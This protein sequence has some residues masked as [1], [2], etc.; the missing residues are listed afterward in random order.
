[1]TQFAVKDIRPNPFRCI[2][3]Y[4]IQREKVDALRES[5]R[6]T[7]YCS[8]VLARLRNGHPEIAYGHHRLV[9]L[10]GEYGEDAQVEVILQDLKDAAMLRIMADENQEQ[11]RT[12]ASVTNETV[13]AVVTAY[14]QGQIEL[15][16]PDRKAQGV[17]YAPSFQVGLSSGASEDKPYTALTVAGFLGW[18]QPKGQPQE[19]VYFALSALE[20]IEQGLLEEADF[21]G[22]N[23]SGAGATVTQTRMAKKDQER[24]AEIA[25]QEAERARVDAELAEQRR[26]EAKTPKD[27]RQAEQEKRTS[28]RRQ[29]LQE[30]KAKEEAAKASEEARVVGRE[31][32]EALRWGKIRADE[33]YKVRY[34]LRPEREAPIRHLDN[35]VE[36]LTRQIYRILNPDLS[37]S[38]LATKLEDLVQYRDSIGGRVRRDLVATLR[39]LASR[40]EEYTA[41]FEKSDN[42]EETPYPDIEASTVLRSG[43]DILDEEGNV[44][45]GIGAFDSS[46]NG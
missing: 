10:Q 23:T 20:F 31:V 19:K 13:R 43:G 6:K 46:Q 12:S 41:K 8:N 35:I 18:L 17:R 39:Q 4:P 2:D 42:S 27:R 44:I 14:A 7:G 45:E 11:W 36:G 29:Q 30:Q 24:A 37:E 28:E 26:Q 38:N 5:L 25:R 32:S 16:Q 1:M 9:A 33:A 3:R 22:L 40:V 15:E 34:D 21:E